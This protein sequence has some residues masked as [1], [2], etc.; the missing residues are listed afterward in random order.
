MESIR[1]KI[2]LL[3]NAIN[4][5]QSTQAKNLVKKHLNQSIRLVLW[6]LNY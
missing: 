5:S 3:M 4:S 2:N 6:R 1:L